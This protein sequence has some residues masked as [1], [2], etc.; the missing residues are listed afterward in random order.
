MREREH[1]LEH[2]RE[3]GRERESMSRLVFIF[4][5]VLFC[6]DQRLLIRSAFVSFPPDYILVDRQYFILADRFMDFLV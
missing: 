2:E 3:R 1:E 6:F 5:R 4:S